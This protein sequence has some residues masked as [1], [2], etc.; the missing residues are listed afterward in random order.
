[1]QVPTPTKSNVSLPT[2][3]L[4]TVVDVLLN[5]T[6]LPDA[7]PWAA[8]RYDPLYVGLEGVV[9]NAIDCEISGGPVGFGV[10]APVGLEPLVGLLVG[11]L[12]GGTTVLGP[13]APALVA[14]AT[15]PALG[16]AEGE[17]GAL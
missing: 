3:S 9:V 14:G 17:L 4:H 2:P 13:F 12:M 1:M 16:L 8:T 7:P 5:S 6:G 10:G 11:L 15:G